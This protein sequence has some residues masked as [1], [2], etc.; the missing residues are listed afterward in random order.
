MRGSLMRTKEN[1]IIKTMIM[2]NEI[3]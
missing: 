1:P 2:Y 3:R